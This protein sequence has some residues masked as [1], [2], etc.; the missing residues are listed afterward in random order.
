MRLQDTGATTTPKMRLFGSVLG[1]DDKFWGGVLSAQGTIIAIPASS[2]V[3]LRVGEPVCV[4]NASAEHKCA[5][6]TRQ[7]HD[8]G[9]MVRDP[10]GASAAICLLL[11][12]FVLLCRRANVRERGGA[13]RAAGRP[14]VGRVQRV[15][16]W[17]AAVRRRHTRNSRGAQVAP[18]RHPDARGATSAPNNGNTVSVGVNPAANEEP[19][20]RSPDL[21]WQEY[22]R[23]QHANRGVEVNSIQCMKFW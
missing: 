3:V 5:S 11:L 17:V 23:D 18:S 4:C 7:S 6:K 8:L 14:S 15:M 9:K 21:Q 19:G 20:E 12:F 2:S 22:A 1:G 16:L 10:L 13:R